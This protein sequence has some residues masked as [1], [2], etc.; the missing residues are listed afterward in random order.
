MCR[1]SLRWTC[2]RC[3]LPTCRGCRRASCRCPEPRRRSSQALRTRCSALRPAATP[4]RL[5]L[6]RHSKARP[7]LL[8]PSWPRGPSKLS[9]SAHWS[10]ACHPTPTRYANEPRPAWPRRSPLASRAPSPHRAVPHRAALRRLRSRE[11]RRRVP[12]KR[13]GGGPPCLDRAGS[14]ASH[15][16]NRPGRTDLSRVSTKTRFRLRAGPSP[17]PG[18]EPAERPVLEE[19]DGGR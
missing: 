18:C 14:C 10:S 19:A 15:R 16:T 11:G 3:D 17:H 13:P 8:P 5:P 7:T 1:P 9:L 12:P 6:I 4:S 2:C